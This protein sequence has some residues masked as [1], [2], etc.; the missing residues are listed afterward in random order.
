MKKRNS[1][2]KKDNCSLCSVN[3]RKLC[4][5]QVIS[6]STFKSQQTNKPYTIFPGVNCSR[7]D[8]IYLIECTLWKKQ[9]V[10]KPET[11]FNIRLNKHCKDVKK[12]DAILASRHLQERNYVF[13]K[14]AK[15]IIIHK[16]TNTTKSNDI[17]SQRLIKREN[18]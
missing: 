10:G 2:L 9:Y 17:L 1:I 3:N 16:L 11:R 18:F 6:S 5:K 12:P 4:C 14:H 8:V 15:F 7:A 13:N